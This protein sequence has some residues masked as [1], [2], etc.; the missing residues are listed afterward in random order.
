MPLLRRSCFRP[1]SSCSVLAAVFLLLAICG[2]GEDSTRPEEETP[3][4]TDPLIAGMLSRTTGLGDGSQSQDDVLVWIDADALGAIEALRMAGQT[5]PEAEEAAGGGWNFSLL[6]ELDVPLFSP[7]EAVTIELLGAAGG[8]QAT[9]VC[10]APPAQLGVVLPAA[11][12]SVS[13]SGFDVV[14]SGGGSDATV[15]IDVTST[16]LDRSWT[17]TTDN[18]GLYHLDAADLEGFPRGGCRIRV[19]AW[20]DTALT[21]VDL[22][23][24]P[25]ILV[26]AGETQVQLTI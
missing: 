16:V 2:C 18:D 21:S 26:M 10:S 22:G 6:S 9:L 20:S 24:G 4:E 7:G 12:T 3:P 15:V 19:A 25:M 1:A 8:T 13:L 14:W 11:G 17:V 23:V 5:D